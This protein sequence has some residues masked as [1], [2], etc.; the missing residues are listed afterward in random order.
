MRLKGFQYYFRDKV[1]NSLNWIRVFAQIN[2]YKCWSRGNTYDRVIKRNV[3]VTSIYRNDSSI[4]I[5]LKPHN[6]DI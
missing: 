1:S 4:H 3:M 6:L 2:G 5:Y